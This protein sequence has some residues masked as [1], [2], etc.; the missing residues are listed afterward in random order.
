MREEISRELEREYSIL[1]TEHAREEE[2]RRQE[3][4]ERSPALRALIRKREDLIFGSIRRMTERQPVPEAESLPARMQAVSAEI[5][6][7]LK[8]AGYPEDYLA[9]IYRCPLCRDT[10]YRGEV[11]RQPCEC[12]VRA[13][14]ALIRAR[15]GLSSGEEQTFARFDL[16]V[17]SDEPLPGLKMSQRSLMKRVR[18]ACEE[19][20][21][22][23]PDAKWRDMMILGKSG[24]GKTYLLRCMADRL[25]ERGKDALLISAQTFFQAARK[26]VFGEG[27]DLQELMQVDVL[28]IDDLGSEPM[29]QNITVEQL[30]WLI[31]ERQNSN[32][33]T[34][35]SSNLSLSEFRARYTERIASR[36]SDP[37]RS[38]LLLLE[39]KDVRDRD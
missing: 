9:P 2:R 23:Y 8:A 33:A 19:L 17:F 18:A 36:M 10:G 27:E 14:Q 7:G 38:N 24:V 16:N 29:M 22:R 15:M 4:E 5:R 30:F 1:R 35:I 11:V 20:A 12:W 26:S 34:L 39:G 6:E 37:L 32:R 13:R 31:N 3:I 25:L 28:M 21:D